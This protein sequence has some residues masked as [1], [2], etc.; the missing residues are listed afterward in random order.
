[1]DRYKNFS[2]LA[3]HETAFEIICRDRSSDITIIAPHGGLIEP[4]TSE[5]A[6]LIAADDFNLFCFNGLKTGSN[7]DLHITSHRFNHPRALA[8]VEQASVVIAVHGCTHVEPLIYVGGLDTELVEQT[9]R[10]FSTRNINHENDIGRYAGI[11]PENICNRGARRKGMQIEISR[12]LRDS[13]AAH[14]TIA[15]AVRSA[16]VEIS[17]GRG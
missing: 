8:L 1:M 7:R 16:L 12:P 3:A 2:D 14:K 13:S 6:C 10:Q 15:A 5:I 17:N 4:H 11:N 9:C